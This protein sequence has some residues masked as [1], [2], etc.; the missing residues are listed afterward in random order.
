MEVLFAESHGTLEQINT[1]FMQLERHLGHEDETQIEDTIQKKLDDLNK[2][3]ERLEIY[4]MKEPPT[5]RQGSRLK[6]NQMKYDS[7]HLGASLKNFQRRR[8]AREREKSERE[9]LLNRRFTTNSNEDTSI[10]I[11]YSLQHHSRLEGAHRGIDDMLDQG[12]HILGNLRD[13]RETLKRTRTKML[14]FMNTLGISNTV[15]NLIERRSFQ[16]K[17]VLYGGMLVTLSIMFLVYMY[18]L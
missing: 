11:D 10:N 7:N 1:L 8:Y 5:K 17:Y 16:D 13:Q 4:V 3:F 2:T 12:H 6:L 15:M 14:S 9:D 18:F